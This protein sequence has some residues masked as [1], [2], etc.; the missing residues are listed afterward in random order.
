MA[1]LSANESRT[2]CSN[3]TAERPSSPSRCASEPHSR[4]SDGCAAASASARSLRLSWRGLQLATSRPWM[5][6][7]NTSSHARNG[8]AWM[9]STLPP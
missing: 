8:C 9:M 4:Y 5:L 7:V 1:A 6:S 2:R 3:T